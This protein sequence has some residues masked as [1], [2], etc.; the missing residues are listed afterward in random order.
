MKYKKRPVVIEA[1][2]LNCGEV[3]P[4]WY[5]DGLANGTI[6]ECANGS[7]EIVT[8]E[9]TMHADQKDYI[10]CGV[11]GEIYPCKPDIFEKT[12]ELVKEL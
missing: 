12:Y 5:R 4:K 7:A 2:K 10:I 1:Y 6:K 9:G 11:N 8:L 3:M